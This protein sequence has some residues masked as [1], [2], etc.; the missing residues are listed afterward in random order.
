MCL[1]TSSTSR[2]WRRLAL[3]YEVAHAPALVFCD[4]PTTGLDGVNAGRVVDGLRRLA[5]GEAL[6]AEA[7]DPRAVLATVHQPSPAAFA[8]FDRLL[9]LAAGRV[10]Y[11]G[12][13]RDAEAYLAG[14]P[15]RG[16]SSGDAAAFAVAAALAAAPP[17]APA[18]DALPATTPP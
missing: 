18:G 1:L 2:L 5:D 13:A 14:E 16:V 15:C 6:D 10:V 11:F 17:K 3:A 8:R 9:L 12:D 7:A 4:E